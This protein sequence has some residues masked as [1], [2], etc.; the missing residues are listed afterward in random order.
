MSI[1]FS[2]LQMS[3]SVSEDPAMHFYLETQRD[4]RTIIP[5]S[6]NIFLNF[7]FDL[8]ALLSKSSNISSPRG[9]VDKFSLTTIIP[10]SVKAA[11]QTHT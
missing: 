7:S 8:V 4:R 1:V 9:L 2:V 5:A 3:S 11:R 6:L 10:V